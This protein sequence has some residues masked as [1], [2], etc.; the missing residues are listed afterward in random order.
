[1]LTSEADFGVNLEGYLYLN[2]LL[3]LNRHGRM[4]K[5]HAFSKLLQTDQHTTVVKTWCEQL[6][7]AR[8]CKGIQYVSQKSAGYLCSRD[9]NLLIISYI[10]ILNMHFCNVKL[11]FLGY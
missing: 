9:L 11:R 8:Y 5:I 10:D 1:M 3:V 7:A 4:R 6:A 2:L